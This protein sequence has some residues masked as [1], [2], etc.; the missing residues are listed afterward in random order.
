MKR[1]YLSAAA[2]VTAVAFHGPAFA[3]TILTMPLSAACGPSA[4]ISETGNL[5]R[6]ISAAQFSGPTS[7]DAFSFDRRLLGGPGNSAFHLTFLT[8]DGEK[9]GDFGNFDVRVLGG[10]VLTLRGH[11]FTY[12][13]SKG[14]LIVRIDFNRRGADGG[15]SAGGGFGGGGGA[16][17]GG[18]GDGPRD[19][20]G[21]DPPDLPGLPDAP[22][23]GSSAD[24]MPPGDVAVAAPEPS[25][26]SQLI[27]GFGATGIWLR[28]RRARAVS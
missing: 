10:D 12:D 13:P 26:W 8:R 2:L 9:V 3:A 17:S 23:P 11:E 19:A 25:A 27:A 14:D 20:P 18:A 5:T 21:L 22:P 7:V 4:C 16:S 28:R 15:G 24:V 1:T 6:T